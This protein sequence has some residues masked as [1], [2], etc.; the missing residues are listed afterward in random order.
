[1]VL[2]AEAHQVGQIFNVVGVVEAST[3]LQHHFVRLPFVVHRFPT[4]QRERTD[5]RN[6]EI[7]LTFAKERI[8]KLLR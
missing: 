5:Y 8:P 4:P 7:V 2:L 1:M 6:A 3:I